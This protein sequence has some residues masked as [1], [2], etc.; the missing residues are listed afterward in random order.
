MYDELYE[1]FR[2]R[3]ES[4]KRVFGEDAGLFTA[5]IKRSKELKGDPLLHKLID[6]IKGDTIAH[7]LRGERVDKLVVSYN[8]FHLMYELFKKYGYYDT[9]ECRSFVS[10]VERVLREYPERIKKLY[11]KDLEKA[12]EEIDEYIESLL[13]VLKEEGMR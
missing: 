13:E 5:C 9:E 12:I 3:L 10:R 6:V 2:D 8:G 7:N 4:F 1:L 11:R